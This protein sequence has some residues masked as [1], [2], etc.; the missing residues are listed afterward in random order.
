MAMIPCLWTDML[1][2]AEPDE[3]ILLIGEAGFR[4]VEFGL[5]HEK[6]YLEGKEDEGSRIERI[7]R[8]AERAG[9][10]I[11][12][13]HGHMFNLCDDNADEDIARAHRSIRRAAQL[14]VRWVVLHP[15]SHQDAGADPE[16]M[17][18]TRRRNLEV[19]SAFARTAEE[20][21]TG[22]AV[23]NMI[24]RNR[25]GGRFGVTT[26]DLL[27]LV[28]SVASDRVGICWDTGHALLS[29]IPQ[30][31]AIR[32]V[33]PRLVA[34]HV[35]DNDGHMDRHWAPHRGK[36]NWVEVMGALHAIGYDGPFNL[37]VPGEAMATPG[38]AKPEQMRYLYRLCEVL[39][40]PAY[41]E[42]AVAQG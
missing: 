31:P 11:V 22:I 2:E 35:A 37:E 13:M 17:E 20:W 34:L 28:A 5:T 8:A 42:Q 6:L 7:R 26:G 30:G 14:G 40:D 10:E 41:V 9:V 32:A 39:L 33:G 15:G 12:Q 16:V 23:E 4:Q 1:T 36:V 25:H 24:G 27:W 18:W 19:F 38:A 3:A 21:G 29:G